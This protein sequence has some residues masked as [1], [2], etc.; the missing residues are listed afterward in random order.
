MSAN[1]EAVAD[2][3]PG[4]D[5]ST[6]NK[7]KRDG[8][9]YLDGA[10]PQTSR[11]FFQIRRDLLQRRFH[12]LESCRKEMDDIGHHQHDDGTI[13]EGRDMREGDED[14]KGADRPR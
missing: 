12:G 10:R 4:H 7:R 13:P 5:E 6:A 3:H 9:E 14:R 1:Y 11:C 2:Q 8:F